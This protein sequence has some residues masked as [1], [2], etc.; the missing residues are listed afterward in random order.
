MSESSNKRFKMSSLVDQ[1]RGLI[2]SGASDAEIESI[3]KAPLV[4][5]PAPEFTVPAVM[6]NKE[7]KDISLSDYRGKWVVL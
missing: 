2:A 3:I 7:F 6:P 4:Q 1:I 5:K